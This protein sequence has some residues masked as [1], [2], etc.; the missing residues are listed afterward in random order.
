[1]ALMTR[2]NMTNPTD[3]RNLQIECAQL[4]ELSGSLEKAR[5]VANSPDFTRQK[6]TELI[7]MEQ[8]LRRAWRV[9]RR[10]AVP[11]RVI[12]DWICKAVKESPKPR[13]GYEHLTKYVLPVATWRHL[14][15]II[16]R[17][18]TLAKSNKPWIIEVLDPILPNETYDSQEIRSIIMFIFAVMVNNKLLI[19]HMLLHLN[20]LV[21]GAHGKLCIAEPRVK[22]GVY[23]MPDERLLSFPV[24]TSLAGLRVARRQFLQEYARVMVPTISA[25]NV[26]KICSRWSAEKMAENGV[27]EHSDFTTED[28]VVDLASFLNHINA[29]ELEYSSLDEMLLN[30]D[31]PPV[32]SYFE[33]LCLYAITATNLSRSLIYMQALASKN[34]VPEDVSMLFDQWCELEGEIW[35]ENE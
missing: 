25:E 22:D 14:A 34:V 6:M 30:T 23:E 15:A 28:V 33:V 5:S 35:K 21:G 29:G 24:F 18:L 19:I 17:S 16:S 31:L 11:A 7:Q 32:P 4:I 13:E 8:E 20:S 3:V 1:M 12:I 10:M 2:W 9:Q 26:A 27:T